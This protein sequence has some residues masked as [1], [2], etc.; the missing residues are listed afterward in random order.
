MHNYNFLSYSNRNKIHTILLYVH[1][2][3]KYITCKMNMCNGRFSCANIIDMK[4]SMFHS[5]FYIWFLRIPMIL[6]L[7]VLYSNVSF[8][9]WPSWQYAPGY[10]IAFKCSCYKYVYIDTLKILDVLYSCTCYETMSRRA[11]T[12]RIEKAINKRHICIRLCAISNVTVLVWTRY[13][14]T[15]TRIGNG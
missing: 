3:T 6:F 9:I 8:L 7:F 15:L 14:N 2:M 1:I 11:K 4:L 10:Q 13:I 5:F 12:L